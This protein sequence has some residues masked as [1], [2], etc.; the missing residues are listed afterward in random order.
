[1]AFSIPTLEELSLTRI[2]R[3]QLHAP[4]LE[5]DCRIPKV[6]GDDDI[7]SVA[8]LQNKLNLPYLLRLSHLRRLSIRES[9]LGDP[10]WSAAERR[11]TCDGDSY[12]QALC[13]LEALEIGA[14]HLEL[15]EVNEECT[16]R[17]LRN[18]ESTVTSFSLSTPLTPSGELENQA[19]RAPVSQALFG[20][21]L[22][23]PNQVHHGDV[24]T[25]ATTSSIPRGPTAL[26]RLRSLQLTP[27]IP[28][29]DLITTLSQPQLSQSPVHTIACTFHP[30]DAA[31]G[32][33]A[34][35]SFLG[36]HIMRDLSGSNSHSAATLY[37]QLKRIRVCTD[38]PSLSDGD[39]KATLCSPSMYT[40]GSAAA[41]KLDHDKREAARRLRALCAALGLEAIID[42][43]EEACLIA[44]TTV[45]VASG[46]IKGSRG[47]SKTA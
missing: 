47:R 8:E 10:M 1:M 14:Y 20:L 38:D 15:P 32:Y 12:W 7:S 22:A 33:T 45:G 29:T 43:A 13:P 31:Q 40:A 34:L 36:T 11:V 25:T 27:L 2:T 17:I 30:D 19:N 35:A 4:D 24:V 23:R 21:D 41:R 42:G 9:H 5:F 16:K 26:P 18:V 46:S 37:R 28:V 3:S 44:Q 39:M 6:Y